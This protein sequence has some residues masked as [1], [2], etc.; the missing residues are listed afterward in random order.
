[1]V[2]FARPDIIA[3]QFC[4]ESGYFVY[5]LNVLQVELFNLL[6]LFRQIDRQYTFNMQIVVI[7]T[8]ITWKH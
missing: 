4:L 5:H 8:N 3:N 7:R 6:T 2:N 1:M